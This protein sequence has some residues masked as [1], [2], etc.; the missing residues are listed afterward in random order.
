MKTSDRKNAKRIKALI[1]LKE[2]SPEHFAAELERLFQAWSEEAW[3]RVKDHG[4]PP[5]GELIKIASQYGLEKEMAGEVIRAVECHMA[6]PGFPTR[7][8]I[9]PKGIKQ[10]DAAEKWEKVWRNGRS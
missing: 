2:S 6:G 3:W 1:A 8:V 9:R 10:T 5:A 7:S 4:L